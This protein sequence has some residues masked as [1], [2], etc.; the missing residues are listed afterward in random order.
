MSDTEYSF[1]F[2]SYAKDRIEE[3]SINQI[4]LS[5]SR[6]EIPLER[7]ELSFTVTE[8]REGLYF[9]S[10]ILCTIQQDILHPV[11][12]E[13]FTLTIHVSVEFKDGSVQQ[14]EIEYAATAYQNW[15]FALP[16]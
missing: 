3:V 11:R 8:E 14:K 16:T 15:E 4:C 6:G 5:N 2:Y 13:A 7:T 1:G 9:G 10:G 12:G